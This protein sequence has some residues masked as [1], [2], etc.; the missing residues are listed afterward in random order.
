MKDLEV[1]IEKIK[2]VDNRRFLTEFHDVKMWH[3]LLYST[4]YKFS[5]ED[6]K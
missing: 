3:N 5:D 4:I 6:I 1:A 2:K